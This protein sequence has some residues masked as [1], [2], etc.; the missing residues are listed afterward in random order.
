VAV[1]KNSCFV[2]EV[3]L[4][5]KSKVLANQFWRHTHCLQKLCNI[6]N[7]SYNW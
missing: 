1:E 6:H 2:T 5:E 3:W 4:P 7:F